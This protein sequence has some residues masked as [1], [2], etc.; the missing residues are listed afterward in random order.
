[1]SLRAVN[2]NLLPVLQALLREASVSRAAAATGLSQPAASRALATLRATLGDPLL[3]RTGGGYVLTARAAQLRGAVDRACLAVEK[4]WLPTMFD[5][6]RAT[7]AFVIASADYAPLLLLP[8][9]LPLLTV[10][11]P[12]VTMRFDDWRPAPAVDPHHMP[13]FVLGPVAILARHAAG[14]TVMP[15]FDDEFVTV[16]AASHPLA[17][18]R[19]TAAEIDACPHILF[20]GD[21]AGEASVESEA[22]LIGSTPAKVVARVRHFAA[23]PML[24]LAT[25]TVTIMPRRIAAIVARDLPIA[26]VEDPRPRGRVRIGLGWSRRFDDDAAHRWFRT[27]AGDALA[28]LAAG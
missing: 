16:A 11:A 19:P 23:L 24:V 7:R 22:A 14:G 3:V 10:E 2:L 25:D 17:G 8:V 13:D 28:A 21:D 18:G 15:L 5:P 4:V 6:A 1:M 9:L 27:R 20:A 26:I 12:G